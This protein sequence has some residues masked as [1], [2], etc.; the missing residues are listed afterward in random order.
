VVEYDIP[1]VFLVGNAVPD[2]IPHG[3]AHQRKK[4]VE[5]QAIGQCHLNGEKIDEVKNRKVD[6][7][8]EGPQTKINGNGLSIEKNR[9]LHIPQF[10]VQ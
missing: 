1:A 9:M 6:P 10:V 8:D 4:S 7:H 2:D 3:D 5:H